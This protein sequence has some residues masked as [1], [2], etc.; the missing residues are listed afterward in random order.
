[1]RLCHIINTYCMI[2]YANTTFYTNQS[3]LV[4]FVYSEHLTISTLLILNTNHSCSQPPTQTE[5]IRVFCVLLS[6]LLYRIMVSLSQ[7]NG[8]PV[9]RCCVRSVQ[10]GSACGDCCL[11]WTGICIARRRLS[12]YVLRSNQ[13]RARASGWSRFALCGEMFDLR[14]RYVEH[15][16]LMSLNICLK[17]CTF[18]DYFANTLFCVNLRSKLVTSWTAWFSTFPL[19]CHVERLSD[20]Q[21][22]FPT[23]SSHF[24]LPHFRHQTMLPSCDCSSW[25]VIQCGAAC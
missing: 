15:F 20:F 22:P 9:D 24:R 13:I 14:I 8:P 25:L 10:W 16:I 11:S 6:R 21:L 1:M 4:C 7:M 12:N 2:T 17:L 18:N 19:T 23:T 5:S 3:C